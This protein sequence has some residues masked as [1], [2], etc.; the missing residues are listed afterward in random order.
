VPGM[1]AWLRSMKMK[2]LDDQPA[3]NAAASR[4]RLG[5]IPVVV[6]LSL[7]ALIVT[8]RLSAY[9]K[10]LD[11]DILGYAVMSHDLLK[12]RALYSDTWEQKPP[13]VFVTYALA[14]SLAGYGPRAV[15]V[16]SVVVSIITLLGV[17]VAG[18]AGERG[19][20]S[21]L[22]AAAFWALFSG[23]L[24][25]DAVSPNAE[26]FMNACLV[27]AFALLVRMDDRSS[28]LWRSLGI[29]A[30]FALASMYKTVV[31]A[32][33]VL[34]ACVHIAFPP[35]GSQGRRRALVQVL[36]MAAVAITSWLFVLGYFV[37]TR[38]YQVFRE[39]FIYNRYYA[40][41]WR[42]ML[43]N[44]LAPVRRTLEFRKEVFP[45][46][47][48]PFV[49]ATGFGV[50]FGIPKSQRLWALL[51]A[52][53]VAT[54]IG[55]ALPGQFWPHYY[56][57]WLPPLAIGAGWGV[58]LLGTVVKKRSFAWLPYAAGA[59]LIAILVSYQFPS[60]WHAR[61]GDWSQVIVSPR[62]AAADRLAPQIDELLAP[63]ETFYVW[64]DAP[65]LYFWTKRRPP[66]RYL[67]TT[68]LIA[69]PLADT[70]SARVA[71][72][73]ER[74]QPELFIIERARSSMGQ[75]EIFDLRTDNGQPE[76]L[77]NKPDNPVIKFSERYRP[78]PE[79]PDRGYFVLFM[80]R[81][82]KLEARMQSALTGAGRIDAME[83]PLATPSMR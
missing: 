24:Q 31:V 38:R 14:E 71:A 2:S 43:L 27:W 29:G 67:L 64:G 73:L 21:G 23:N 6:L 77:I 22:W 19:M 53:I 62:F 55:I 42:N 54:W 60:Y 25:L 1:A 7:A 65:A 70:C 50:I 33:P 83:A 4:R 20:K 26:V 35:G 59:V 30:L 51:V 48:N 18:S 68:Y 5:L 57:L 78:L 32:V 56:Q 45:D 63:S 8:E 15:F 37:A 72:D 34:L 16:L 9:R 80:R 81:G 46:F 11:R 66:T 61:A 82:G 58:G 44:L 36:T 47:L 76:I 3:K 12:G 79:N 17:Y 74:E 49:I 13:G 69:G 75:P 52:F 41:G 39:I 28:G 40:G 10:P